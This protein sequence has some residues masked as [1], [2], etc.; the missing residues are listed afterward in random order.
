M[1]CAPP[2]TQISRGIR[3][4][5][6]EPSLCPQWVAKGSVLLQANSEDW[7]DWVDAQVD[8]SLCWAHMPLCWVCR[9][10]AQLCHHC[11][12]VGFNGHTDFLWE[13]H[14][15]L[16]C[17]FSWRSTFIPPAKLAWLK[18][19]EIILTGCKTKKK[20]KKKKKMEWQIFYIIQSNLSIKTTQVRMENWSL[21]TCHRWSLI[22]TRQNLGWGC[23]SVKPV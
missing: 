6:S 3:P 22:R 1:I 14:L 19:S 16:A 2:K 18:M 13:C 5:W 10:A 8:L 23:C 20:K 12:Q 7:S 4:V 15:V 21:F 17:G 9:E 11:S